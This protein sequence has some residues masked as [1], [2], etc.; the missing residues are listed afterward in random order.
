MLLRY[1]LD[2]KGDR[3]YTTNNKAP[4]GTP[5][6]SAHPARFSPDD[7]FSAQRIACK[8][9]FGILRTQKPQEPM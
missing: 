5:T 1:Y 2:S 6:Y 9:R 8:K 7:K 4:D 3:V